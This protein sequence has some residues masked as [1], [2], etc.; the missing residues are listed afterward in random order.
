MK[1]V[2]ELAKE[3]EN[4]D[5][6]S[7]ELED[8]LESAGCNLDWTTFMVYEK[9]EKWVKRFLPKTV[10]AA[11][12]FIGIATQLELTKNVSDVELIIIEGNNSGADELETYVSKGILYAVISISKATQKYLKNS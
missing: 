12:Y 1:R 3:I 8:V 5:K 11:Q 6:V 9:S 10:T 7:V 2:Y 4:F